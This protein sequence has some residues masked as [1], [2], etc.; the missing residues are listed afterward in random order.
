MKTVSLTLTESLDPRGVDIIALGDT[1]I[2]D[3][4]SD[5][6]TIDE[7]LK[8]V[9][10][11]SNRF[12]VLSGDLMDTAI[13]SSV[14]DTY[15]AA[16]SPMQQLEECVRIFKPLSDA[17]KIIGIVP[18]NHEERISKHTGVD[19]TALLAAQ[20]GLS[21][22]YAPDG[23]L[24]FLRVGVEPSGRRTVYTLYV[25]HGS[26]G[27][28]KPGGKLNRLID[29]SQIVDADVYVCGHT[30]MP[31]VVKQSFFRTCVTNSTVN[32]VEKTFVNTAASLNYGGYGA[33][34]GYAPASRAYPVINLSPAR[35]KRV[36]V[37]V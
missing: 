1:H 15:G 4:L 34:F 28:R 12:C 27:G 36:T 16:L 20:L 25:N 22:R 3:P 18:G 24:L 26:G 23:L 32:E 35:N 14:G 33:R 30:H 7:A 5:W 10:S 31:A 11:D 21:D 2:G 9:L 17:G 37:S 8:W 13:S 19:T 29:L 6:N